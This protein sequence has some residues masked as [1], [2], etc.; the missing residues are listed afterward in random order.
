MI[1]FKKAEHK[2]NLFLFVNYNNWR[3][4]ERKETQ[5]NLFPFIMELATLMHS[6]RPLQVHEGYGKKLLQSL[7]IQIGKLAGLVTNGVPK[8][9]RRTGARLYLFQM[10]WKNKSFCGLIICHSLVHQENLYV[11][12]INMTIVVTSVSKW[13]NFIGS[14]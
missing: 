11:N 13:V 8:V 9:A 2:S 12:S 6:K 14:I 10:I 5:L 3:L 4:Y 1:N 7:L